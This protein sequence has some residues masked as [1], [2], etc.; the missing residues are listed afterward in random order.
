VT[1][2]RLAGLAFVGVLLA[3]CTGSSGRVT[4]SPSFSPN[5]KHNQLVTTAG[6]DPC[7]PSE[8]TSV[9]G[10]LPDLTLS[11]LGRGPD[12][13]LAGLVGKP[14][15]LNIWGTWCG[16]CQAETRYLSSVYDELKPRVRFLGVDTEESNPDSALAFAP[17][18]RPPMRYPSVI[19]NDKAVLLGLHGPVGVPST[20]FVDAD[21][22]V[23]RQVSAPYRSADALRADITRYLGVTG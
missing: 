23:V 8:S 14:V 13:H 5:P 18:V 1:A 12:V 15:V 22:K 9:P 3:G 20:V 10:G 7:P 17:H 21:G 11:C 2:A 16:P 19:D 4:P 6:L